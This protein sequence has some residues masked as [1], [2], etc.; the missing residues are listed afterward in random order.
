MS[1]FFKSS[2]RPK[3]P[4]KLTQLKRKKLFPTLSY[5]INFPYFL[6]VLS[7]FTFY[8]NIFNPPEICFL[9]CLTWSLTLSPRLEYSG[10]VS[11]HC[12]LRLPTSS[13]SPASASQVAGTT[14]IHYHTQLI[15]VILVEV[16]LH[17]V[18]QAG[19]EL[20]TQVIH[21]SDSPSAGITGI[22]HHT[23]PSTGFL[24]I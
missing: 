23:Q 13:D 2:L 10:T 12:N 3:K 17:H 18:G 9:V 21:A 24:L 4:W 22:S 8:I 6:L 5:K 1:L 7:C 11:A 15:L 20:S 14:G 16:G 19:L